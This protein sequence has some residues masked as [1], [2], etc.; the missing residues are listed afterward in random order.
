MLKE[1]RFLTIQ[2]MIASMYVILLWVFQF[3]SFDIGLQ[4]RIAE[5]LLILVLFSPKHAVG[6]LIGTFLGNFMLSGYG[7]I[8]AIFG[9]LASLI[10]I[11]L[12]I[13]LRKL[14]P[15]ALLMPVV[16][17]AFIVPLYVI[18]FFFGLDIGLFEIFTL[19][20]FYGFAGW[21]ALGQFT[22]IF[23]LGIPLYLAMRTNE[24]ITENL[25]F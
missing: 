1:V 22:V 15:V 3:A 2:A 24:T 11:L 10:A 6:I 4:F 18:Y 19:P 25:T 23:V 8:D 12:M 7:F 16:V 9:T 21:V 17:N 14:W 5:V 13:P 20:E